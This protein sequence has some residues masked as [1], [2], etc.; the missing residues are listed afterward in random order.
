MQVNNILN[1]EYWIVSNKNKKQT[2]FY[3]DNSY[4]LSNGITISIYSNKKDLENDIGVSLPSIK[5]QT[6]K[7]YT[8]F[9]YP[10]KCKPYESLYEIKTKKPLFSKSE[11]SV[12]YYCAGYYMIYI[13]N[14]WE[15]VFCPKLSTTEKN[16]SVGPFKTKQEAMRIFQDEKSRTD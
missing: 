4:Y 3:Q 2:V 7:D 9:G 1:K 12:C 5:K 8:C 11:N 13:K 14:R 6:L 15:C 10:T 16:T